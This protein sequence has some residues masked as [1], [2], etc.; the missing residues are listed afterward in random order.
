MK[1][2]TNGMSD[3]Y[4]THGA[5]TAMMKMNKS[6]FKHYVKKDAK[7]QSNIDSAF[8]VKIK[9]I[10]CEHFLSASKVSV[11][12]DICKQLFSDISNQ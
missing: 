9:M 8:H 3:V 1:L 6:S 7:I 11:P 12:V 10:V 4:S 2:A 5:H